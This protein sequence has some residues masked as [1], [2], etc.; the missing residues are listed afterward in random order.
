MPAER[1]NEAASKIQS[2]Y[3]TYTARK[4]AF[5]DVEAI[6]QSFESLRSSFSCPTSLE[7][8]DDHAA[9]DTSA[10]PEARP[11][12]AYTSSNT[13]V[14]AYE[15]QL[16]KLLQK[17]DAIE[18]HGDPRVR[19][20][21]R[22]IVKAIEEELGNIDATIRRMWE[23]CVNSAKTP[24]Q[25]GTDSDKATAEEPMETEKDNAAAE[26]LLTM[27]TEEGRVPEFVSTAAST[28]TEAEPVN[29]VGEELP[30]D[31][32]VA[33][34]P[35]DV[36]VEA[37]DTSSIPIA[38]DID[39]SL[40]DVDAV[41]DVSL[42][43]QP[44]SSTASE[45]LHESVL[46]ASQVLPESE[47]FATSHSLPDSESSTVSKPVGADVVPTTALEPTF[48][49]PDSDSES[50]NEDAEPSTPLAASVP[51]PLDSS[52]SLSPRHHVT[53]E[54]APDDD[55]DG[56][57]VTVEEVIEPLKS[58]VESKQDSDFVMV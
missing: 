18:S 13:P 12:L 56:E 28:A 39:V 17:L 5:A 29:Q 8:Q 22:T 46:S 1:L 37:M 21:R 23:E 19:D 57:M 52:P 27:D 42:P 43:P 7:F 49:E 9:P 58:Q 4:A 11:R 14:H 34:P 32:D 36:E 38:E 30:A 31:A 50:E 48:E 33:A 3:R 26:M 40:A 54:D 25:E 2:L 6:K 45:V 53:V 24:T 16:V 51:L 47:S 55:E 15:D 20:A 41:P 44:E 10:T 35:R